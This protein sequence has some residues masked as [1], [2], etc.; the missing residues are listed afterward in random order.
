MDHE[1]CE[2]YGVWQ[3]KKTMGREYMGVVRSTALIDPK[4]NV[5]HVFENVSPAGHAAEVIVA[6]QD[7]QAA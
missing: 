1:I 6:L 2:A 5:A 3:K 7:L 4:G